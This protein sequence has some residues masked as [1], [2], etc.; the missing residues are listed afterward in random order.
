VIV[1][2]AAEIAA[3]TSGV[4]SGVAP[5]VV[6]TDVAVDSRAVSPGSMFVAVRGDRVDGHDFAAGAVADGAAVVLSARE[7]A[8]ADGGP[9]PCIVVDDPVLALGRLAGWVRRERLGCTVVAITGSSGKTST[10][11]L[12]AAVLGG[13]GP[14]VSAVGSFNTEVGLPLTILAADE[15]TRF[16]VLEMGMRGEG[17]IDYLVGLARPDVSAVINVGTATLGALIGAGGYG[18][19]ILAGIRLADTGLILEGAVPAALLALA[20]QGLFELAERRLVPRGLRLPRP[21]PGA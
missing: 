21:T 9:L 3:A 4:L 15:G 10:K 19:P 5:E 20:T 11:D 2:S 12:V 7:L 18:Q 8:G 13:I 14:T 1:L 17:H 6:V 16:L